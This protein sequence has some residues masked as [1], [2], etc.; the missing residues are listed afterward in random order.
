MA[1]SDGRSPG[2]VTVSVEIDDD[3]PEGLYDG[4]IEDDYG[5]EVGEVHIRIK[6]DADGG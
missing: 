4:P 1:R 3:Q 6:P 5:N 2:H